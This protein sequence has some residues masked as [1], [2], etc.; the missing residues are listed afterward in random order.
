VSW[1]GPNLCDDNCC[2]PPDCTCRLGISLV[3]ASSSNPENICIIQTHVRLYN[4]C[5]LDARN[6]P[7]NPQIAALQNVQ[8]EFTDNRGNTWYSGPASE[9]PINWGAI[10]YTTY[11]LRAW[12][13]SGYGYTCDTE[14]VVQTLVF[15]DNACPCDYDCLL[16]G[17]QNEWNMTVFGFTDCEWD[18]NIP[19]FE[20]FGGGGSYY[21]YT[22]APGTI[23]SYKLLSSNLNH[24]ISIPVYFETV[25]TVIGGT[26]V[27]CPKVYC[28]PQV[29]YIGELHSERSVWKQN[30]RFA[31]DT[32]NLGP[33]TMKVDCWGVIGSLGLHVA[34]TPD[35]V[36]Y[37]IPGQ[38]DAKTAAVWAIMTRQRDVVYADGGSMWAPSPYTD[39]TGKLYPPGYNGAVGLASNIIWQR[40]RNN[41]RPLG[42]YGGFFTGYQFINACTVFCQ[43]NEPGYAEH[44]AGGSGF[45]C[46][47]LKSVCEPTAAFPMGYE[48]T[49]GFPNNT[50]ANNSNLCAATNVLP[51]YK[52]NLRRIPVGTSYSASVPYA[53]AMSSYS[54]SQC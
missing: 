29:Y 9:L 53:T 23:E 4:D 31:G 11:T 32:Q 33:A 51:I 41:L 46:A 47:G 17:N 1:F 3:R 42:S 18:Y 28:K 20:N 35:G 14:E 12:V 24:S 48:P 10:N 6:V 34:T 30:L 43:D 54:F 52:N 25:P 44:M 26:T 50:D 8:V 22:G 16:R 37:V 27:M 45:L 15:P 40:G 38:E 49:L 7:G 5:G 13:P 36:P 2:G 19:V 21:Q 39:S